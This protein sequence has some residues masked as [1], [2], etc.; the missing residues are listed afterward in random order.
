MS[1][2]KRLC[3]RLAVFVALMLVVEIA[4]RQIE[5]SPRA[6]IK[7]VL[8]PYMMFT[9]PAADRPVWKNRVT[10]EPVP[11]TMTFNNFGFAERFDFSLTPD[12]EY[13]KQHR[14]QPGEELVLIS[15][16]SAAAGHGATANDKTIAARMEHHLNEHPGKLLYRVV[17]LAMGSWT[18]YQEF[19]GLSL[20]GL[21]LDPDWVVVMDGANDANVAC[22]GGSGAGRPMEW[23]KSLYFT[24]YGGSER[25]LVDSVL[26]HSVVVRIATGQKPAPPLPREIVFD[27]KETDTRFDVKVAN[28][29]MAEQDRQVEFYLQSQRNV[30]D[31]FHRANVLFSTQPML[32][33]NAITGSYR[34]AF[35]PGATEAAHT[36]LKDE[37]DQFMTRS[38]GLPC[39]STIT[40]QAGSYFMARSS[41]RLMDLVEHERAANPSRIVLYYNA[42]PALPLEMKKRDPYFLDAAHMSDRGQD[43]VGAFYADAI[44][45]ADRGA[46]FDPASFTKDE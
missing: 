2:L 16:G 27:E 41:L 30:L 42:E 21:P 20:F 4:A 29:T 22:T 46:V 9:A 18:S 36:R 43:R 40:S 35:R 26:R 3:I 23:A 31:L 28:L 1:G 38:N 17:N 12:A 33:E 13:V 34:E 11:S 6:T 14:K 7:L 32:Y 44:L 5:P 25:S 19:V 45:S 37:L 15:G 8:Q 39:N 24:L 10:G